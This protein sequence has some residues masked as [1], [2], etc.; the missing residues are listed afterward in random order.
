MIK[1]DLDLNEMWPDLGGF[2]FFFFSSEKL[3]VC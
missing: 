3:K 2:F 1:K